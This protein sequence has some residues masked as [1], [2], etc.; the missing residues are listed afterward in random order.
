MSRKALGPTLSKI[1]VGTGRLKLKPPVFTPDQF[2][3]I[4]VYSYTHTHSSAG[5]YSN[6]LS[7]ADEGGGREGGERRPG[8][9]SQEA[10]Q[11]RSRQ[12]HQLETQAGVNFIKRNIEVHVR[13]GRRQF[14]HKLLP[15]S[16]V[17]R[18][19]HRSFRLNPLLIRCRKVKVWGGLGTRLLLLLTVYFY[20]SNSHIG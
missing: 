12:K 4:K 17:P 7:S 19:L 11:E 10:D 15:L 20:W 9:A 8:S 16:L 14:I 2:L 1:V 6:R 5:D 3:W 13:N 18:L